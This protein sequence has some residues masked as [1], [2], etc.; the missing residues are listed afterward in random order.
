MMLLDNHL[1]IQKLFSNKIDSY[2]RI[3]NKIPLFIKN[4][5]VRTNLPCWRASKYKGKS[6][7]SYS[8]A[9]AYRKDGKNRKEICVKL[10]KLSDEAADR[11]RSLLA[12]L[13]KPDAF[14]TTGD[15]ITVTNHF[16]YLDVAVVRACKIITWPFWFD[17]V[18]VR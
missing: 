6:Y 7:R 1:Y 3:V 14:V 11:W 12:T 5:G 4:I 10:G 16:A 2:N 18:N 8:L 17:C 15:N 9:R 13:K